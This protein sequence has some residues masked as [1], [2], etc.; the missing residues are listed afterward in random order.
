MMTSISKK[1]SS[2]IQMGYSEELAK[3]AL[4]NNGNDVEKT[5]S[6][7][8]KLK[9]HGCDISDTLTEEDESG[10]DEEDL[11]EDEDDPLG[12]LKGSKKLN[13]LKNI[14][15]QEDP[16]EINTAIN[17]AMVALSM[18]DW[19]EITRNQEG[20]LDLLCNND[21]IKQVESVKLKKVFNIKDE[22]GI[23]KVVALGFP[24]YLA[25][26]AFYACEKNI[27]AAVKLLSHKN[28]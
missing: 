17:S 12:F 11:E 3:K 1:I 2:I 25:E 5:I 15:Y 10:S 8:E 27:D 24:D 19:E 14:I 6:F 20:F 23:Q 21:E 7:L 26:Q 28:K 13:V 16:E 22:E 4:K 9:R 18:G